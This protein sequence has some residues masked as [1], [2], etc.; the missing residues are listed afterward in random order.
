MR[1]RVG[2]MVLNLLGVKYYDVGKVAGP[3]LAAIGKGQIER[4]LRAQ[5]ANGLRQGEYMLFAHVFGEQA[6]KIA[7]GARMRIGLQ[8]Y[9]LR[10]R[11]P[12][13]PPCRCYISAV[14]RVPDARAA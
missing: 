11:L 12:S 14:M 6:G 10:G 4:R 3:Q 7:V 5:L 1:L 9:A 8:K 2:R 13:R